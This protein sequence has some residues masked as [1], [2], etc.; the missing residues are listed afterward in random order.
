MTEI[1]FQN[2]SK[3]TALKSSGKTIRGKVRGYIWSDEKKTKFKGGLSVKKNIK[4]ILKGLLKN[5]YFILG[6]II[7]ITAMFKGNTYEGIILCV[8]GI[9]SLILQKVI[10]I[11]RKIDDMETS[12]LKHEILNSESMLALTRILVNQNK[13]KVEEK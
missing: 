12:Y 3:I 11:Q 13:K 2:G 1:E 7:M 9:G 10:E 6:T 8:I 5:Y 4:K